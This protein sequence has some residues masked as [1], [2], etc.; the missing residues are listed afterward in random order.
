MYDLLHLGVIMRNI[1]ISSLLLSSSL[2]AVNASAA[3][4]SAEFKVK[5]TVQETC[6]FTNVQDINF[7][8]LDRSTGVNNTA[9]GQLDI[10]CTLGTPYK[11]ALQGNGIMSKSGSASTI[12][13]GLFKDQTHTAMWDATNH[14]AGTGTGNSQA[15]PVYAKLAGNT[16]VEAGDY[17]DTVVATV[18]Y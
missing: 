18:T 10:T 5:I 6:K 4:D 14:L 16:N 13:Y 2:F 11:I 8:T 9:D 17:V 1:L 15:L 7:A 3:T 12:G